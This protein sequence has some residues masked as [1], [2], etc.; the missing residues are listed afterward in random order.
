MTHTK[1]TLT[2]SQNYRNSMSL[3]LRRADVTHRKHWSGGKVGLRA[4]GLRAK[5]DGVNGDGVEDDGVKGDGVKGV[6]LRTM[7]LRAIGLRTMGLMKSHNC[8][9]IHTV[10][11]GV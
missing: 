9:V 8:K 6:G 2:L 10:L 3:R 11:G 1:L 7:G 4:I 5:D